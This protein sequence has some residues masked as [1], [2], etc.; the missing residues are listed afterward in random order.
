LSARLSAAQIEAQF[1]DD[2]LLVSESL[3]HGTQV[4]SMPHTAAAEI[5]AWPSAPRLLVPYTALLREAVAPHEGE[6]TARRRITVV[7][8][9]GPDQPWVFAFRADEIL[10]PRA[11][12]TSHR[13]EDLRQ[14]LSALE[15]D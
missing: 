2:T 14:V 13:L 8:H 10:A 5:F 3:L 1:D 6:R 12:R 15:F 4:L 11:L 7:V 9:D